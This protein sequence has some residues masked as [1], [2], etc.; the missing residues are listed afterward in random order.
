MMWGSVVSRTSECPKCGQTSLGR[1][2][3]GHP[4]CYMC[5]F[6]AT[7][8]DGP[9]D[10]YVPFKDKP[11]QNPLLEDDADPVKRML[12][13]YTM[14]RRNTYKKK[15]ESTVRLHFETLRRN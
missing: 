2:E 8:M 9:P 14:N 13:F 1:D 11:K 12:Y 15:R 4:H 6:N 7:Y 10:L 5:G 3:E